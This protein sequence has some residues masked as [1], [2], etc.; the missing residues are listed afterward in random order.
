[1]PKKKPTPKDEKPQK[2]RFKET[3]KDIGADK[4]DPNGDLFEKVIKRV[5]PPKKTN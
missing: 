4:T 1:M 3:A 5:L 2:D